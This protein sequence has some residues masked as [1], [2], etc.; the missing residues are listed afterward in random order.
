MSQQLFKILAKR[1]NYQIPS[2]KYP[3]SLTKRPPLY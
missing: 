2:L 1:Y 3:F